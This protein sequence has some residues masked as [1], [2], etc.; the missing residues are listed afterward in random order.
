MNDQWRRILEDAGAVIV[1]GQVIHYG[2]PL[3]ETKVVI[4]GSVMADLSH[5]GLIAVRG[6][7]AQTFLQGQLTNDITL[8]ND[9]HSQI[10][11]YCSP[12]GRLLAIFHIFLRNDTYY[13]QLPASLLESVMQ[14][15]RKYVLMS[16]VTLENASDALVRIVCSGPD[17]ETALTTI[18]DT[19]PANANE[20]RQQDGLTVV[21]L[22][23]N[24]IAPRYIIHGDGPSME[25]VWTVLDA[26]AAPVGAR[27]WERLDI[28][29]GIPEVYPTTV[30]EFI[31]QTVNLELLSGV[32]FT[33]GCY[34]GQEIVTRLQHR[35]KTKRRMFRVSIASE[36]LPQPG[37]AV[38]SQQDNTTAGAIVR[39]AP[40]GDSSCEALAVIMME[41]RDDALFLPSLGDA[42]VA[43]EPLPY[44]IPPLEA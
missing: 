4:S 41:H 17:S 12:K 9:D 23:E 33:K 26:R 20:T 3:R 7:D 39:A 31:P 42:A 15:L 27:A 35:G 8:V 2:S 22:P 14:R 30:E 18:L 43:L 5:Y 24:D 40:A 32:S 25:K 21:R 11:G 29:S 19:L 16:Q 37:A 38:H 10:S 13:L 34:T 6:K 1:D 28:R 36:S 44:D